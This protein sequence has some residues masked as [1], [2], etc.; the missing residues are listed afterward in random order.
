[1]KGEFGVTVRIKFARRFVRVFMPF[2]RFLMKP[3]GMVGSV[4]ASMCCPS[5][6]DQMDYVRVFVRHW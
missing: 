1:M 2:R 5:Y 6:K 4:A 3:T